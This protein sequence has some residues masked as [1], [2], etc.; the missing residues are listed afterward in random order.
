[1]DKTWITLNVGGTLFRTFKATLM[2]DPDSVLFKMFDPA[3]GWTLETDENG[4]VLLDVDP[5]YFTPILNFLRTGEIVIESHISS[6]GVVACAKYL[7]VQGI[8]DWYRRDVRQVMYSWGSGGSGELGTQDKGDSLTPT[9]VHIVPHL[10][11]VTE[12][13]LGANYS[14][15]LTDSG[16]VYSFGNGDWGQLGVGSPKYFH[17]KAEDKTPIITIPT[18][19]SMLA[20]EVV[21]VA[22]GYAYAMALTKSSAVY[23][24]GNNNHGQSGLGGA[25]FGQSHR[26]IEDPTEVEAF[27][28]RKI[29]QLGCGSFFVLALS[30]DGTVYSW[31]LIDCLGHGTVESVKATYPA[32]EIAESVSKDKRCVL[33]IPHPIMELNGKGVIRVTAGQWHSCAITG[34][35]DLYTWGVGFQGRLGHGDKEPCSVP[36]K[37]QGSLDGF[38]VTEVACGSFH[39]VAL[40]KCGRVFCWGDNANGQCGNGSLPDSVT[41]P[42]Y[43]SSLSV[44]SGGI[45]SSIS[46]GRQHTAVVL[47]GPHAWCRGSC[48]KLRHDGR[49]S[50]DHGQVFVFG[51]SKGMGLGTAQKVPVPKLVVGMEECNV[52]RV[53]SGLH[54]TLVMAETLQTEYL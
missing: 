26:K 1:M 34:S 20:G 6:R 25:R 27:I 5:T 47:M 43:V 51:E 37:V 28:G 4:H 2:N 16:N 7:Q 39:T 46:C 44:M 12:V 52:R 24:W 10:Q 42:N 19:I 50:G 35:G 31:G 3:S 14:C 29:V 41:L 36:T 18:M 22:A 49:A 33:L 32:D 8:V 40:T 23:F 15:V 30:E 17:E 11:K 13:A 21:S 48:C 45:V 38:V 9:Q 53:V 54:H